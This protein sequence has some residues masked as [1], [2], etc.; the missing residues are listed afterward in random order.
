MYQY[1]LNKHDNK[2]KKHFQNRPKTIFIFLWKKTKLSEKTN[3][4][5]HNRVT[6]IEVIIY[7]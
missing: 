6:K 7:R 5:K 2:N 1:K 4:I 3:A